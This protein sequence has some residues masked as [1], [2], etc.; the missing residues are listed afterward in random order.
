[1]ELDLLSIFGVNIVLLLYFAFAFQLRHSHIWLSYGPILSWIFISPAQHQIHHSMERRHVD[2]NFGF[3]LAIWDAMF[4]CLYVPKERERFRFGVAGADPED[5]SSVA[6]IYFL[7]FRK[8][9]HAVMKSLR[10]TPALAAQSSRVL[11]EAV[12]IAQ[13][14]VEPA[15]PTGDS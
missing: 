6:R 15:S 4:G 13:I 3:T 2:K 12:T 14:E 8:A 7:P 5:F 11:P 10:W 1:V 9:A